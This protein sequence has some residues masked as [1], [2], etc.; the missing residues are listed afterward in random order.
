MLMKKTSVSTKDNQRTSF[1][2]KDIHWNLETGLLLNCFQELEAS[3]VLEEGSCQL[4]TSKKKRENRRRK[5]REGERERVLPEKQGSSREL[6]LKFER[7]MMKHETFTESSK[8]LTNFQD[9]TTLLFH[10]SWKCMGR[11]IQF[12]SCVITTFEVDMSPENTLK[13]S[14]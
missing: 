5:K 13:I 9:Y 14:S 12:I 4:E 7:Q 11:P 3:Q 10:Y 1:R 2:S 6:F 8:P